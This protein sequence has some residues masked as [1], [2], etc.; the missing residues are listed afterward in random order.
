MCNTYHAFLMNYS[1]KKIVVRTGLTLDE[2]E[3]LV[4]THFRGFHPLIFS[5][6]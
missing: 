3:Y 1:G 6:E 2:A 4:R 5:G